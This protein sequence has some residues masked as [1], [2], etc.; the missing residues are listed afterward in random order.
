MHRAAL[1]L[2]ILSSLLPGSAPRAQERVV[3]VYNWS[4][5]I[6]PYAIDRFQ[7]ETGIRVRYDVYDSLE[8]LEGKLLAGHSGYD[9]VVPTSEPTFSRLIRS[10]AL[11]P[12]DTVSMPH[13]AGLDPALMQA[14]RSSD[15]QGRYGAIYLWG[16]TGLGFNEAKLQALAPDAPTDSWELLFRPDNAR[17]LAR[18]GITVM[19]SATD[20]IPSV[21]RMLGRSPD[22]TDPADLAAVEK[23]L[24][25]IRPYIRSFASGGAIESLAA[26]ETCLALTYSGDVIQAGARAQEA[27]Q[28]VRVR[29]M[30]PKEG[31]QLSFDMLAVPVDA[32]H[33]A[34]AMA[35]IDFLLRPEV[36]AGITNQVRYANAV[37]ASKSMVR[38]EISGDPGIYPSPAAMAGF[39][40]VG[41][42]PAEATRARSRMWARFKAGH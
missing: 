17:R 42:V 2:I 1:L 35:F 13:L 6:D 11:Q 34:E 37:P 9:V 10:G 18:C 15:P 4:D 23:A 30:A 32:P 3:N 21:L 5:Y 7:R 38:P 8:I 33:K 41:P 24:L 22:S 19:D 26:G 27:G 31:A 36:M 14:V 16:T 20:V 39:F 12:L 40:T 29:Y 28:G 25:A